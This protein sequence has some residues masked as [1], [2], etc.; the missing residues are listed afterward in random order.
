MAGIMGPYNNFV[1]AF[2]D[3]NSDI[4]ER[5]RQRK[6][7]EAKELIDYDAKANQASASGGGNTFNITININVPSIEDINSNQIK[8]LVTNAVETTV[9]QSSIPDANVTVTEPEVVIQQKP[10]RGRPRKMLQP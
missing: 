2:L 9:K 4:D 7:E 5:A 10:K 8:E 3:L 1:E 6:M